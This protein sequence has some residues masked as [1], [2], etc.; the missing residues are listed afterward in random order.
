MEEEDRSL[1]T[2]ENASNGD[3]NKKSSIASVIN[4]LLNQETDGVSYNYNEI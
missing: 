2:Q 3:K 1:N 4:S